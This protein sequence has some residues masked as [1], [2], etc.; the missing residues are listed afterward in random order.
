MVVAAGSGGTV[1]ELDV[2]DDDAGWAE[3]AGAD[4]GAGVVV[5]S[6]VVVVGSTVVV[7]VV[8]STVVVVVVG[9]TV[10]VVVVG[11]TVVVVVV[12][13]IAVVVA[14]PSVVSGVAAGWAGGVDAPTCAPSTGRIDATETTTARR[15]TMTDMQAIVTA[16]RGGAE[17]GGSLVRQNSKPPPDPGRDHVRSKRLRL[18]DRHSAQLGA[19][20]IETAH[21]RPRSDDE[22]HVHVTEE[23]SLL[24]GGHDVECER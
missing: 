4:V 14:V 16:R 13:S 2:V 8:G 22:P 9:S 7:V 18:P 10:V 24:R 6:D 17:S 12:G 5:S 3:L 1:V 23:R 21:S 15:R 19:D 20:S 11:L